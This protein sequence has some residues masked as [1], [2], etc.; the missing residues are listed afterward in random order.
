ME[1]YYKLILPLDKQ[2]RLPDGDTELYARLADV[3]TSQPLMTLSTWQRY[4]LKLNQIGE[5]DEDLQFRDRVTRSQ[6]KIRV[7][8]SIQISND[9]SKQKQL[10]QKAN[11][12][13]GLR[14]FVKHELSKALQSWSGS[15]SAGG[16]MLGQILAKT[17]S[18]GD[19]MSDVDRTLLA[20]LNSTG[21]ESDFL[22][23]TPIAWN[24]AT[25]SIAIKDTNLRI[26]LSDHDEALHVSLDGE[27]I[28][29]RQSEAYYTSQ[30]SPTN[31]SDSIRSK[32]ISAIQ[33]ELGGTRLQDWKTVEDTLLQKAE[34]TANR[35][36]GLFG[37]TLAPGL[38]LRSDVEKVL[39]ATNFIVEADYQLPGI[40][41]KLSIV[42]TGTFTLTDAA[43]FERLKK[44]QPE[45][46]DF[47]FFV[48]RQ[49]REVTERKLQ[50]R[51]YEEAI[52]LLSNDIQ[53]EEEIRNEL[54]EIIS[55]YGH[56]C[57]SCHV[58]V[59]NLPER[60]LLHRPG[61]NCEIFGLGADDEP[62]FSLAVHDRKVKIGVRG[63]LYLDQPSKLER[64][65]KV[66]DDLDDIVV[67]VAVVAR[68]VVRA[69][70]NNLQPEEFR[71]SDLSSRNRLEKND[72]IEHIDPLDNS[73]TEITIH[74]YQK[75]LAEKIA[76]EV[77]NAF[78]IEVSDI[79][80]IKGHE[81]VKSRAEQL[82]N[83][84]SEIRVVTNI[85]SEAD[86][87]DDQITAS[88]FYS[89]KNSSPAYESE[90][91]AEVM[92]FG[93]LEEHIHSINTA[94]TRT[95]E[96]LL[97]KSSQELLRGRF[98]PQLGDLFSKFLRGVAERHHGVEIIIDPSS[99]KTDVPHGDTT[100]EIRDLN[101]SLEKLKAR[102]TVLIDKIGTD[103]DI[104][105]ELLEQA[106]GLN[107]KINEVENMRDEIRTKHQSAP[108]DSDA[109]IALPKF[110]A[111]MQSNVNSMRLPDRVAIEL[112]DRIQ[113][114]I[115]MAEG[116]QRNATSNG[117]D[118]NRTDAPPP[119]Q[120]V[121]DAEFSDPADGDSDV[122]I[123]LEEDE[124]RGEA[125]T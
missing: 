55:Q 86:H 51:S 119:E 81:P 107:K 1:A 108:I 10:V 9:E 16:K 68:D 94:L 75:T 53:L 59:N 78:G 56:A 114:I 115:G 54:S 80:F 67:K 112:E 7:S 83:Y 45:C 35:E 43:R 66:E 89:I 20:V 124:P 58:V 8:S 38:L 74:A 106:S 111:A 30:T 44:T 11:S 24:D 27:L 73:V 102:R 18:R 65:L 99:F 97:K 109:R 6:F 116:E 120:D 122:E 2:A 82:R 34:M 70:L 41:R 64:D 25:P 98:L 100:N 92:R 104:D 123:I 90:F 32:V 31:G 48:E 47:K 3:R 28:P 12:E 29:K 121:Q 17:T 87:H 4:Q 57:T 15:T 19:G 88:L 14:R 91:A 37:W 77:F 69:F 39:L 76:S 103:P 110:V 118:A 62:G 95:F 46:T 71:L 40:G 101:R 60:R 26:R 23:L 117:D 22:R 125:A 79:Q 96:N 72:K 50:R 113:G 84:K 21:L 105:Q 33:R 49:A 36:A 93:E 42:H 5:L 52:R 85:Y 61:Y 13:G 63:R